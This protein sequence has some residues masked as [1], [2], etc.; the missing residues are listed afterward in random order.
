MTN[1]AKLWR[2]GDDYEPYV[3]RWSRPVVREFVAW[4][5]V[6]D[7]ARWL[8]VGCGT[9]ALTETVLALAAPAA[10]TGIDQSADFVAFARGTNTDSRANFAVADAV[11]LP[12]AAGELDAV[13][14]GLVLN[15]I[16]APARSVAEMARVLRPGGTVGLY[17]WDYAGEMQML[18]EFWDAAVARDPA[19]RALDEG[20]RFG[21]LCQPAA[22][23][24]LLRDAGL[25]EV[26]TRVIDVPTRFANFDDFWTP[27]LR[28]QA[29]APHY[30]MSLSDAA[31]E[32]L[33]DDLRQR[34]P[35]AADGS[36]SLVARA[37]AVQGR[38]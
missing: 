29:P 5:G 1:D 4:L 6:A 13:G 26:D 14:S 25:N 7:G 11:A 12:F 9:G 15:F 10:I 24:T 35:I 32:A 30:L 21:A 20:E 22:L 8:D 23:A 28:A 3:G 37:W 27:F 2:Q 36:I 18:R 16:P 34:L 19:A 38:R 31:R 33:R 17:V